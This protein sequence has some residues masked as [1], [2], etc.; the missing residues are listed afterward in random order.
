MRRKTRRAASK[1]KKTRRI[2]ATRARANRLH[3]ARSDNSRGLRFATRR[4]PKIVDPAVAQAFKLYDEAMRFFNQQSYR[5][6]RD[7]FAKVVAGPSRELAER[8]R[9]HVAICEQRSE[10]QA[11]VQLRSA[12]DH[13]HFAV[14]QIN[15]GNYEGARAHLE[16]ARKLAPKADYVYYALASVA[17]L[18]GEADDAVNFLAQAIK[19][20]PENRYHAR[21]DAD[22]KLLEDDSR[23][24]ALVSPGRGNGRGYGAA[25]A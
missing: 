20:R 18:S 1:S 24:L 23:F 3:S 9:V 21:N 8:A 6:A 13:Y 25:S 22:F 17:S 2:R 4:T 7:L 14:S 10:R 16:K 11:N 19:L 5:R 15:L 12:D